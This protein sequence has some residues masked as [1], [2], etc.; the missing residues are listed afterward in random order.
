MSRPASGMNHE[1][2]SITVL[3]AGTVH[4]GNDWEDY[5]AS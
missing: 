3:A 4:V 2:C 5:M 1:D